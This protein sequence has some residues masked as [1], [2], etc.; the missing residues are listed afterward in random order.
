MFKFVM[1]IEGIEF[2]DALRLLAQKAGIAL[3]RRDP[4]WARLQTERQK[5]FELCELACKFFQK[6]LE[7]SALGREA[8]AYLVRRGLTQESIA[9]WR[10]G[11]APPTPSAL[12]QFARSRGYAEESIA[13]AG[14]GIQGSYGMY[15]RFQSRIM[16]PIFDLNSQAIGFGGRIFQ[17]QRA[18]SKEP[19]EEP[20]KYMN[21]PNTLLYDKSKVLYGLDKAKVAVHQQGACIVVEGYMDAIMVSQAGTSHVVA[22]S[23]TAFTPLQLQVLKRYCSKLFTA[24]DMDAAGS[25]ATKKSYESA[26][27]QGFEVHVVPMKHK[28]PADAILENPAVW[29]EALA[30]ARSLLEHLFEIQC[31]SLDKTTAEGKRKIAEELLPLMQKIPNRIEQAHWITRLAGE[32]GVAEESVREEMRR[33]GGKEGTGEAEGEALRLSAREQANQRKKT[34]QELL[35]ERALILFLK[36]PKFD[37]LQGEYV[38]YFSLANQDIL[39]G[40]KNHQPFDSTKA[41][42]IFEKEVVDFLQYLTLKG[43]VEEEENPSSGAWE[44]ELKDCLAELKMLHLRKRLG[45]IVS[46]LKEAEALRDTEKINALLA[47][48]Q[49]VSKEIQ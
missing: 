3:P 23:G 6:Q 20:A 32:L 8:K 24:F 26:L 25:S 48:F 22:T 33:T 14:L 46:Q 13:K 16:F 21:T 18:K 27:A 41:A 47:E 9:R 28:D 43:E 11:W 38:Q 17:E 42:E 37:I 1:K 2:A 29:Q 36:D 40:I 35:E 45:H 12:A 39:E 30:R 4:E 31:S 15:D 19:R 44:Q 49:A 10:L 7:E 5:L 34:R